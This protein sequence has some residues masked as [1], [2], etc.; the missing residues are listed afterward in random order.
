MRNVIP[1]LALLFLSASVAAFAAPADIA[2]PPETVALRTS[3]LPGYAIAEQ[4]C[5]ICHSADYIAYQPPAMTVAQWTAE[6]AKMQ[7]AYGAPISDEEVKLLGIY[8]A[9]AYGN[10][11]QVTAADVVLKPTDATARR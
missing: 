5:G 8:L 10:A 6:M 7:H 9:S 2:L 3:S 11:K 1:A 4:K